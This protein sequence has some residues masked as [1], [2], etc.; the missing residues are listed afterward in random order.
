[1]NEI[2]ARMYAALGGLMF[3]VCFVLI[4]S[5]LL[6]PVPNEITSGGILL[7]RASPIYPFTIQNLM[8]LLFFLGFADVLLR[9]LQ[10]G[11]ELQQMS[12]SLLPEDRETMLRAKDLGQFY[13]RVRPPRGNTPNCFLQ[14]LISRIILQFQS[15][16]S[17]DQANNLLNSSLELLQHEIDLKYNM[18]RYMVWLI[19]TLGFIGTVVGIALALGEAGNMPNMDDVD[20][21]GSWMKS[22]TGSLA[23]AFNTTLLALVLSAVLV[24]LMH[25]AQGR[26]EAALNQA[27]QYCLDNLI[28]RLYEK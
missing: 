27:G 9:F 16:H 17:V 6:Q 15:S 5:A 10:S 19:P 12:L 8:W 21:L 20:A 1:M 7:D 24:F 3:G 13:E 11:K 23:L 28:N 2:T 14:R 26:E 18:M 25:L 4:M 22:L